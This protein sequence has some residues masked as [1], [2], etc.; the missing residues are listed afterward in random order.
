MP[1]VNHRSG[2]TDV[3]FPSPT[4]A[5]GIPS[6]RDSIYRSNDGGTT[7]AQEY[8]PNCNG[9][10]RGF[11]DVQFTDAL[12][13]YSPGYKTTDGGST[14]F[15]QYQM[16]Q[17][18]PYIPTGISFQDDS[19][20]VVVGYEYWGAI[21]KTTDQGL[22]W[23][24]THTPYDT[25]EIYSVH[26]PTR[27][28]GYATSYKYAAAQE[29]EIIKTT[30]GGENWL[31][32]YTTSLSKRFFSIHC[33]DANTCYAVGNNGTIEKTT[34][35]GATWNAQ[36]SGTTHTL[37][38]VIFTDANTGYIVGDSGTILKTTNAGGLTSVQPNHRSSGFVSVFPNPSDGNIHVRLDPAAPGPYQFTLFNSLGQKALSLALEATTSFVEFTSF[39]NGI[40]SYEVCSSVAVVGAGKLVKR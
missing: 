22:T 30:D 32:I 19:T 23:Y 29:A 16:F 12:T 33:T 20:G 4:V 15:L 31:S 24:W 3:A 40:Y 17:T 26:F 11:P 28:I 18:F 2:F 35:G 6:T 13:G 34:D 5:L 39:P 21:G 25:W 1:V 14:W 36:V 37:R 9:Q 27:L 38:K 8:S 10:F 7:W